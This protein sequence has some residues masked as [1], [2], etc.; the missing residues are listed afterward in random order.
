M[1]QLE[2]PLQQKKRKKYKSRQS[3]KY[4]PSKDQTSKLLMIEELY[5]QKVPCK[6]L[7]TI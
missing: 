5:Y 6:R 1:M 2:L 7:L 4:T 3:V